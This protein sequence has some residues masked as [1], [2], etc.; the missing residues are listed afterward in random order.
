MFAAYSDPLQIVH[1]F[2]ALF[3]V[4]ALPAIVRARTG[5]I[6]ACIGLYSAWV[7]VL[8]YIGLTTQFNPASPASWLV[9][10]YD[11]TIGW[12]TVAWI[13]T[14]ACVYVMVARTTRS[15]STQPARQTDLTADR[16]PA[17]RLPR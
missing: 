8:Y 5:T 1:S 3:A 7:C 16:F 14:M 15:S 12:G 2:L 6:A 9:G 17:V 13:A 4:G 10:S 11:N